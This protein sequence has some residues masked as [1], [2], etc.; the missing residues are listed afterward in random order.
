MNNNQFKCAVCGNIYDKE[1][2]EEEAIEQLKE[3][4]GECLTPDDCE[5]VCDDCYN[6][7]F[8]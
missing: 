3:E 5:L 7:I 8:K 1:L 6:K 2:T 4:F